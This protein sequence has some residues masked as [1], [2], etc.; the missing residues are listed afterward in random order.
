[1]SCWVEEAD[2]GVTVRLAPG[3]MII[4]GVR[5]TSLPGISK[6][7][8]LCYGK[9]MPQSGFI[10]KETNKALEQQVQSISVKWKLKS[11]GS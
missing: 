8:G 2:F 5:D 11:S 1:M 3:Y 4:S 7:E 10:R 9:R 6:V